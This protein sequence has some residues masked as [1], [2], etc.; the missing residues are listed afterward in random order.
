MGI[1]LATEIKKARRNGD[2]ERLAELQQMAADGRLERQSTD[3]ATKAAPTGD[4]AA[5]VEKAR[6]NGDAER[7]AELQTLAAEGRLRSADPNPPEDAEQAFEREVKRAR[8]AGDVDRLNELA[9]LAAEDRQDEAWMSSNS[10]EMLLTAHIRDAE[11]DGDTDFASLLRS[12]RGADDP[13]KALR[14]GLRTATGTRYE[15]L[16]K[17]AQKL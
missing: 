15:R 5:E 9:E 6:K 16:Q 3:T 10:A 13:V 8:Q 12:I 2:T 7:L 11:A 1:D 4:V 17:L 14:N